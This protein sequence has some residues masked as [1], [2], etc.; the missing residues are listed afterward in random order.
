[1]VGLG[2]S[3]CLC[4]VLSFAAGVAQAQS[5]P[6][7]SI[8]PSH[9][10]GLSAQTAYSTRDVDHINLFNGNLTLTLPMGQ[11]YPV[12]GGFTWG[13]SAVYNSNLWNWEQ[14]TES[15]G[16]PPRTV[17]RAKPARF[18][19]AGVGW[20]LSP[21]RLYP[22]WT[23]PF[24]DA[25]HFNLVSAD[26]GVHTFHWTLH[27]NDPED[28]GDT[29]NG[30]I[31]RVQ[32]SRDGSYLRLKVE[33]SAG[34][35]IRYRVEY[36][37]GRISLFDPDG[38]CTRIE[39]SHGNGVS[40]TP[41]P[42]REANLGLWV[43]EDDQ[44]RRVKV[45]LEPG[46]LGQGRI[47][48]IKVPS[49]GSQ[50]PGEPDTEYR[51]A[52]QSSVLVRQPSRDDS[53]GNGDYMTVDLLESITLPDGS[54]WNLGHYHREHD[55]FAGKVAA[56]QL[57]AG[58]WYSWEYAF[59]P[60][61]RST[62]R[63]FNDPSANRPFFWGTQGVSRRMSHG[64]GTSP[65]AAPVLGVWEYR[66][67]VNRTDTYEPDNTGLYKQEKSVR[68]TDPSGRAMYHYFS[69][70]PDWTFG[71][72]FSPRLPLGGG[73]D[74]FLSTVVVDPTRLAP[75]VDAEGNPV[76]DPPT[77]PLQATYFNYEV[78]SLEA[79]FNSKERN[80]RLQ[81][82]R[83][84]HYDRV[85]P[86]HSNSCSTLLT[87]SGEFHWT[88]T[89]RDDF[90]GLGHYRSVRS[91]GNLTNEDERK[92]TTEY[93][94]THATY[95]PDTS[96][97]LLAS[98]NEPW[99]L[100]VYSSQA[101]EQEGIVNH[102]ET[103]FEG[104]TGWLKRRRRLANETEN[105]ARA[106]RDV[107]QV[108]GADELG[109]TVTE[110]LFGGDTAGLSVGTL[111]NLSLP[112]SAAFRTEYRYQYG[113]LRESWAADP[114]AADPSEDA[115]KLF[116]L[117]D[118]DID[119]ATGFV[120]AARDASGVETSYDFD[121]MG[122]VSRIAPTDDA[123]YEF[124]Y[125][126]YPESAQP[127][128]A[129]TRKGSSET[130]VLSSE[131]TFDGLGRVVKDKSRLPAASGGHRWSQRLMA[132][133]GLGRMV[134]ASVL[135]PVGSSGRVHQTFYDPLGRQCKERRA[136][137]GVTKFWY[138]GISHTRRQTGVGIEGGGSQLRFFDYDAQGRLQTVHEK[139]G[140]HHETG[141]SA[142]VRTHYSYDVAGRLTKVLASTSTAEEAPDQVRTFDHDGAGVL[143]A[144]VPSREGLPRLWE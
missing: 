84:Y 77:D 97:P 121:E 70:R 141:A 76:F 98:S 142:R 135:H 65:Q 133:D 58:G 34:E 92:V 39:D 22:P 102:V 130:V 103:C 7:Y 143:E 110:E 124:S 2:R 40:I 55:D 57:P 33:E 52:Y 10:R 96:F 144:G 87:E 119:R 106:G 83:T 43:F 123:S 63:I 28:A 91:T 60:L 126:P 71:L 101:V 134:S 14:D 26:G 122:R 82:S 9:E 30:A 90:D 4:L 17:T 25:Q 48:E 12:N 138:Q 41:P 8:N 47:K 118:Q 46:A 59:L 140:T 107:V 94:R 132:Y 45:D 127:K 88:E 11:S 104:S 29:A 108:F 19:N 15:C 6:D 21:G 117:T 16:G 116:Q 1:M 38:W 50:N 27:E 112:S 42:N 64:I 131:L 18:S 24:E 13:L 80:Q 81:Q 23:E 114:L 54:S 67:R 31:Q 37:D 95:D 44:G 85:G 73:F 109:N 100:G 79:I 49:F 125:S 115:A 62:R 129:V 61:P 69:T 120:V 78:D 3:W 93:N 139:S 5:Q 75:E 89:V 74:G 111:C 113:V 35:V 72:P 32:Y 86:T 99:V 51:F 105:L 137:G 136:D 20:L 56:L 66:H 68:V 36:P 128:A 53:C